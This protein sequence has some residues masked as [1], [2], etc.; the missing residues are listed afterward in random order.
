MVGSILS[1]TTVIGGLLT[2]VH[3]PLLPLELVV[4]HLETDTFGLNDME[5]LQ[6]IPNLEFFI[7]FGDEVGEDIKSSSWR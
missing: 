3:F 6:I 4:V 7:I 5:G 2:D 1:L